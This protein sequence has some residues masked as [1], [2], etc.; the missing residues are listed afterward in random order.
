MPQLIDIKAFLVTARTGSFSAA[1]REIGVAPSVITK[2]V[3]RLENEIAARLFVRSTRRLSLT[4]EGD[5]L[6]PRLQL[7]VGELEETLRAADQTRRG[8]GGRLRIKAPTT[9]SSLYVGDTLAR[10]QAANPGIVM[11]LMLID[12]SVNPI[13]EGFDVALGALPASYANVVDIPLCPYHRVL[14]A[15]P[16]YVAANGA[17]AHPS[18]LVEHDCLTFLPVGVL[19]SFESE[20]GPISVEVHSKFSVNDSGVLLASAREG[21]GLAVVPRFLAEGDLASGRL[22]ALLEDFPMTPL[23]FKAMVPRN[24]LNKPAV[25]AV[26]DFLKAEYEPVPPWERPAEVVAELA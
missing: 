21:N 20:S 23:W 18:E 9:I 26:L 12:R 5:R 16:D 25:Q 24:K 8:I 17:P 6:R 10:F 22:V 1:S 15:A 19:W 7:L 13:E 2:R 4:A 11:E 14:C 3:T